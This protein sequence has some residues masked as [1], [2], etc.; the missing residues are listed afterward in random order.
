MNQFQ[1]NELEKGFFGFIFLFR[2]YGFPVRAIVPGHAG[3]RN[4]KFLEKVS[5]TDIACK[6]T[7]ILLLRSPK[8][9]INLI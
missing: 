9:Y 2:A 3:A 5:V 1:G 7:I 4:C 6:V 8:T